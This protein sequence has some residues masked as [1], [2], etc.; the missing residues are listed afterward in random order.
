MRRS[1][2][3]RHLTFWH[4]DNFVSGLLMGS[5]LGC[6]KS[7][8]LSWVTCELQKLRNWIEEMSVVRE[9]RQDPTWENEVGEEDEGEA[10][11]ISGNRVADPIL[12]NSKI[13]RDKRRE[14]PRGY[15]KMSE[16]DRGCIPNSANREKR[17]NI[18]FIRYRVGVGVNWFCSHKRRKNVC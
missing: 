15:Q 17:Q 1:L 3:G 18:V 6:P 13:C 11:P 12:R 7:S 9:V 8:P 16:L 4:F 10:P 14:R 2:K 5:Q